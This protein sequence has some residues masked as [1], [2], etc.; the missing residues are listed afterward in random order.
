[1][2]YKAIERS[3]KL[4][5]ELNQKHWTEVGYYIVQPVQ[6]LKEGSEWHSQKR[7]YCEVSIRIIPHDQIIPS[8][9]FYENV[10]I[11][12]YKEV[13]HWVTLQQLVKIA[14]IRYGDPFAAA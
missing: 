3:I 7:G 11:G 9:P 10:I 6:E 8:Q 13:T 1:M 14:L 2:T 4:L 5:N 12:T